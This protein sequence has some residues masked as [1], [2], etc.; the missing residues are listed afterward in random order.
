[1][2]NVI[3]LLN[4]IQ[5]DAQALYV[6]VHNYHWNV[7][8]MYFYAIHNKTEEIYNH[9]ATVYDDMAERAIQLGGKAV[10]TMD[11]IKNLTKIKEESGESFDGVYVLKSIIDDY[12]YLK[13]QFKA[14]AEAAGE[15]DDSTTVAM[16]EDEIALL[17]KEIWMLSASVA[18]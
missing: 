18:Q 7:K 8:G 17:E 1:M 15:A 10:L 5:A 16:A 6:K 13:D 4:Q 14:L 12:K 9:L 3:S 2:E 11:A